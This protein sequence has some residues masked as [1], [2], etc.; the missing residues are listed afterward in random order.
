MTLSDAQTQIVRCEGAPNRLGQRLSACVHLNMFICLCVV[1]SCVSWAS[2]G[3][4]RSE[5]IAPQS[6]RV[7]A[8]SCVSDVQSDAENKTYPRTARVLET[9]VSNHRITCVDSQPRTLARPTRRRRHRQHASNFAIATRTRARHL[10]IAAFKCN[11]W[12]GPVGPYLGRVRRPASAELCMP[13]DSRRGHGGRDDVCPAP[14]S[15]RTS[16]IFELYVLAS[17]PATDCVRMGN[18]HGR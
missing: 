2:L 16:H 4:R 12:A 14:K 13:H 10:A 3:A 6:R 8:N 15:E 18:G 11:R 1:C 7:Y 9:C 17:I 5:R